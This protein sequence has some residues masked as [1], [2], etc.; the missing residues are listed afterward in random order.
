MPRILVVDDEPQIGQ[1]LTRVLE[2]EGFQVTAAS[3]GQQALQ[4][5]QLA[6]YDLVIA[7][8][9]MPV[10]SGLSLLQRVRVMQ[11][12]LPVMIITGFASIDSAVEAMKL[13]ACDYL[14]KPFG[15]DE[16]LKRV[17]SILQKRSVNQLDEHC[18][19]AV[20]Q[21]IGLE[22]VIGVSQE[23]ADVLSKVKQVAP[24]ESTVLV[25][26]ET[27]VGKDLIARLIHQLSRRADKPF[28][29]INC[30]A[31]PEQLL[32]SELF[33]H[34]K[35]AFTGATADRIGLIQEAHGGTFFLDEIGAMPLGVQ[36][37]LLRVLE[38][39]T[40]R[41][42]GE[43]QTITADV[44]IIAAT[45]H[46]LLRAIAQRHFRE[47][48]YYRLNVVSIHVPPLRA[49]RSDI[50]LLAEF[51]LQ[52]YSRRDGKP[53]RGIEPEALRVLL[54]YDYPGNVRELK[55]IIE[56][57]VAVCT[58][59]LITVSAL[60][61]RVREL[62]WQKLALGQAPAEHQT[63]SASIPRLEVLAARERA[64]IQDAINRHRGNLD[65]AARELGISRVTLWRRM[66]KFNLSAR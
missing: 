45:N 22:S 28:V 26:G 35:G 13:G 60:P 59:P 38:D 41:R 25:T 3:N 21:R 63:N 12:R 56:Q 19:G 39:H 33:G 27:G 6:E 46:D 23:L 14:C 53:I 57:A 9:K 4:L 62:A 61:L 51:F 55:H 66:K 54:A 31:F 15:R 43:N 52:R 20:H 47:D 11:P 8:W 65:Q 37:K 17:H 36:A 42:L 18:A 7:D 58:D 2:T 50:P 29:S 5:I 16:L 44:R 34:V 10:M 30:A 24:T 32:E 40:I 48:L 49:R 64:L 1:M